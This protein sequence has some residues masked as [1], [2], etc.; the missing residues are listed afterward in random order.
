MS[1]ADKLKAVELIPAFS[2]TCEH[3]GGDNFARA[4]V[5]DLSPEDMQEL[6][7]EHGV[8]SWETGHFMTKP[9]VVSCLHCQSKFGTLDFGEHE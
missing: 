2:W 1:S 4:M 9:D 6:A 3:C 7:A 5:A 8:E